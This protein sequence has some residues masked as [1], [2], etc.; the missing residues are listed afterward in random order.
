M[1]RG[2]HRWRGVEA[3]CFG[4]LYDRHDAPDALEVIGAEAFRLGILG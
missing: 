3:G 4:D 1:Q 2:D